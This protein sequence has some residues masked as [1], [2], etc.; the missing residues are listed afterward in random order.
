M[1]CNACK[2]IARAYANK[3]CVYVVHVAEE[4]VPSLCD[5]AAAE[6]YSSKKNKLCV[7]V[8]HVA[9]EAVL[10]LCDVAAAE[11]YSSKKNAIK[12]WRPRAAA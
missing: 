11:H 7:Y 9:E 10:S 3:L 6:H 4:A 5:V 12:A 8:V 2:S 1:L